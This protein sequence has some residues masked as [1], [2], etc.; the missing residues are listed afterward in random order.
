MSKVVGFGL[1][2]GGSRKADLAPTVN[3]T[4]VL[5]VRLSSLDFILTPTR[6]YNTRR[7][8]DQLIFVVDADI[9]LKIPIMGKRMA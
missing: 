4:K 5:F 8:H 3:G 7:W 9:I 6:N 1:E 2:N